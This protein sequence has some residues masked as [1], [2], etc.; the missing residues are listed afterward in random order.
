MIT[1]KTYQDNMGNWIM[2][3]DVAMRENELINLHTGEK[4]KAGPEKCRN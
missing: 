1:H 3:K 2:P 4:I